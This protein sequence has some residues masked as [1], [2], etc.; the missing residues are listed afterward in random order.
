MLIIAEEAL[1]IGTIPL[2]S[3]LRFLAR[4]S[5]E[6]TVVGRNSYEASTVELIDPPQLRQVNEIQHRVTA[7][8]SQL[9]NGT[10]PEGFVT[11]MADW[12]L[13]AKDSELDRWLHRGWSEAKRR[14]LPNP[15][16]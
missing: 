4:L 9:L 12:V 10:C 7:C 16:H 11:S 6:L 14:T 5:F 15:I 3:Q 13:R 1:W 2:E 8:L